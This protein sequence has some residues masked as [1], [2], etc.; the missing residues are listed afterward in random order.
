[1]LTWRLG[2]PPWYVTCRITDGQTAK[3]GDAMIA[4]CTGSSLI[5]QASLREYFHNE[6]HEALNHQKIQAESETVCYLTNLLTMYARS[7]ELFE[8]TDYGVD[9]KPLAVTYSEALSETSIQLRTRLMQRLGDTALFIAGVFADSLN[10]KVVDVDYYV[11]MGGTAYAQVSD[12]MRGYRAV[13]SLAGLFDELRKKFTA[14]VDVLNEVSE[15]SHLSSD[16]DVLRLYELWMRTGSKRRE[17][18]LRALGIDPVPAGNADF[19][20]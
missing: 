8:Q 12:S 1:M 3:G 14:F 4:Q 16:K 5:T 13:K 20:H 15:R 18:Q 9:I 19:R 10:R 6:L 17:A 7:D 2:I 11:A